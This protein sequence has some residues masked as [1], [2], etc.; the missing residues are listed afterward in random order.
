MADFSVREEAAKNIIL[1]DRGRRYMCIKCKVKQTYTLSRP[2]CD[3]RLISCR[4]V[5]A[6]RGAKTLTQNKLP[7]KNADWT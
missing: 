5:V 3:S 7:S 4:L 6:A 1:D 2:T